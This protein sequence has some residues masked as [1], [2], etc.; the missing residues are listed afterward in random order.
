MAN[1]NP[2]LTKNSVVINK[3]SGYVLGGSY[4]GGT[5]FVTVSGGFIQ[6]PLPSSVVPENCLIRVCGYLGQQHL[7]F[8]RG[9]PSIDYSVFTGFAKMIDANTIGVLIGTAMDA[10]DYSSYGG[11]LPFFYWQVLE[12]NG[13][14]PKKT[15]TQI[16][17]L[18][19]QAATN[20]ELLTYHGFY[21][22]YTLSTPVMDASKTVLTCFQGY[23]NTGNVLSSQ[24]LYYPADQNYQY[25]MAELVDNATVRLHTMRG[26]PC[27]GV[28][29]LEEFE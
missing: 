24:N 2:F 23:S 10:V 16:I 18:P 13:V 14:A 19:N 7:G 25:P 26:T 20:T 27:F 11:S 8:N 29:Q 3:Y 28:I 17:A 4:D 21:R 1:L 5:N 15:N 9:Q 22:E 6:V 12:F